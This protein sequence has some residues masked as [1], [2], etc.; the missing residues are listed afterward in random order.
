MNPEVEFLHAHLGASMAVFDAVGR[1]AHGHPRAAEVRAW[2]TRTRPLLEVVGRGL[3]YDAYF[4][5]SAARPRWGVTMNDLGERGEL[6]SRVA[7]LAQSWGYDLAVYH[8]LRARL[9]SE[10]GLTVAFGF[11][12]PGRLPRLK[13]YVQEDRWGDSVCSVGDLRRILD[14]LDFDVALPAW[15]VDRRPVGVVTLDTTDEGQTLKV[16]LGG[17]TALDAAHGAPA[18]ILEQARCVTNTCPLAPSYHYLT[19]RL[20]SSSA[21]RFSVNKIYNVVHLAEGDESN[22]LAVWREVNALFQLAGRAAEFQSLLA[23]FA[24]LEHIRIVPTAIAIEDG[25]HAAD[26]YCTGYAR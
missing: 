26:V 18:E 9:G 1:A 22:I 25:G 23:A 17:K 13:L 10:P 3:K 24:P 7:P 12:D 11:D 19:L 20:S 8:H 2:L 21:R 4:V 14:E 15:L 6:L 5:A 16:Y